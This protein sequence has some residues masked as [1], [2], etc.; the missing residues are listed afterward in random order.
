MP[1]PAYKWLLFLLPVMM[2]VALIS[3]V[4]RVGWY[5]P[6]PQFAAHHGF[7]MVSGLLGT[8]ISLERTLSRESRY[9]LIIPLISA[10][11]VFLVLSSRVT[12]G[13]ALQVLAAALLMI[14]YLK[15]WRQLG[16]KFLLVL[17]LGA[18]SW[19]MSGFLLFLGRPYP[20]VSMWLVLFLLYTIAGERLE[21]SR[22]VATPARARAFLWVLF[23]SLL[24]VQLWPFHRGAS[25]VNGILLA[26]VGFWLVRYDLVR[27][28]LQKRG[29]FYFTGLTLFLGYLWLILAGVLMAVSLRH[30]HHYDAVLHAF[31]LGF[32]FSMVYAHA[33]FVMPALLGRWSR[34]YH[35]ALYISVILHHLVMLLRLYSDYTSD[36]ILRPWIGLTQVGVILLY[37]ILMVGFGIPKQKS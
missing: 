25:V 4:V 1:G 23:I 22:F 24:L 6:I 7:L 17:A 5:I 26:G 18:F 33:P 28:N 12:W 10:G 13:F 3:A 35:P 20:A 34:W 37:L 15:Q 19:G 9:W 21:L 2:A 16:H 30:A 27:I 32:T 31:F 29:F 14:L 8:M 11:A 36:M